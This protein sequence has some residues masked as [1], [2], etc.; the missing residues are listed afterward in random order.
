MP[1][2]HADI[3]SGDL[4]KDYIR[5]LDTVEKENGFVLPQGVLNPAVAEVNQLLMEEL[6]LHNRFIQLPYNLGQIAIFKQKP[7]VKMKADGTLSLPIDHHATKMLWAKD[8]EAQK[9]RRYVYHRNRHS[10]GYVASF[11]WLKSGAR[12]KNIFGYKFVPVKDEKRKL[13]KLM[14]D[15]LIQVEFFEKPK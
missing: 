14:K 15:P 7:E 5:S 6:M 8:P 9:N 4:Y 11:R 2:N 12:T 10:G 13:A 1:R 3:K